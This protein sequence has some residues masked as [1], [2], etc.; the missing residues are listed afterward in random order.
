MG[1][2]W[3]GYVLLQKT[4]KPADTSLPFCTAQAS[5]GR[6]GV[7]AVGIGATRSL[8]PPEAIT[9]LSSSYFP[10]GHNEH[11]PPSQHEE[12]MR[13]QRNKAREPAGEQHWGENEGHNGPMPPVW[14]RGAALSLQPQRA[15][16]C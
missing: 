9:E 14:V 7:P 6:G 15:A 2:A 8:A 13:M 1:G 11:N 4:W 16:L 12:H 10:S 3:V 5:R